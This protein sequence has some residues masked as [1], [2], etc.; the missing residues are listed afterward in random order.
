MSTATFITGAIVSPVILGFVSRLDGQSA[1]HNWDPVD[2]A[3]ASE[4]SCTYPQILYANYY[5]GVVKHELSLPETNPAIFTF[6]DFSEEFGRLKYIDATRTISEAPL[7][8]LSEDDEK[9]VFLEGAGENYVATHMIFK[10]LGTA[11]YTKGVNLIGIP[12]GS[13][14]VGTCI[15]R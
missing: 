15:G 8:K 1:A 14:A 5:E 2:L 13:L 6:S 7:V 3:D 10:K 11:I 12:S 4:I 9:I